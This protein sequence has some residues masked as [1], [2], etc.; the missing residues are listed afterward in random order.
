M[1]SDQSP[2]AQSLNL[3]SPLFTDFT[4]PQGERNQRL[5][6]VMALAQPKSTADLQTL[7]AALGDEDE[8]IRWLAGSSLS[9]LPAVTLLP[10]LRA[11]IRQLLTP[12]TQ[13]E[14]RRV[15]RLLGDLSDDEG[16]Q[17]EVAQV[18]E[19]LTN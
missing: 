15:L 11:F 13:N 2:V 19:T 17:A 12:T 4:P 6:Q 5:K 3:Q 14:V 1:T 10:V 7:V 18:L 8:S 16:T 9:R